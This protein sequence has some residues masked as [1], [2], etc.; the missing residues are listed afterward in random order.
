[1]KVA[2]IG[3]GFGRRV[4][5]PVFSATD[6]CEVAGV[7]SARD[8]G[9]VREMVT[10]ADVDL[11]SVH[12]PPFLHAPH[13]RLALAEGKAVLCDKPFALDG[14]EAAELEA[15]ARAA[16]VVALCNFEFRYDPARALLRD[17]VADGSLGALEH[18]Q[19]YADLGRHAGAAATLGLALRPGAGRRLDRRMG[20]ARGRHLALR[21]AGPRSPGSRRCSA[22]TSQSAPTSGA[23]S[24]A[25]PPRTA[26][27][28]RSRCRTVRRSRSTAGSARSSTW[29]RAPCCSVR[30]RLSRWWASGRVSIRRADGTGESIDLGAGS[31]ADAD[32][33]AHLAPM[34]RFAEVVRDAVDTGEIPSH[35]PTFADG[36]ACDAVLDLLRAEPIA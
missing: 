24:T 17:M 19:M 16:G 1:M 5:A 25:A 35:A 10:R 11:V 29:R 4:V 13:V 21:V 23:S 12:S 28:R 14:D 33:D 26:S 20:I 31:G 3:S 2:V 7:V 34:R 9:A 30:L 18:V 36:R 15:E 27:A 22:S 6:G 32:A 8:D